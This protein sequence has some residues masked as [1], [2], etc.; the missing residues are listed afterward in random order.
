VNIFKKVWF[1]SLTLSAL[2]ASIVGCNSGGISMVDLT[3]M[4][5]D[6]G[7]IKLAKAVQKGDVKQI[8]SLIA[9]GVDPNAQTKDEGYNLLIVALLTQ[10]KKSIVALLEAGADP[11]VGDGEGYTVLHW[12]ASANDPSYLALL[13]EKGVDPNLRGKSGASALVDAIYGDR[14]ENFRALLAAGANPNARNNPVKEG[15]VGR[16]VLHIAASAA[17]SRE[18]LI[19][20][21]AGAEPTA[22]DARGNTFQRSFFRMSEDIMT[23]EGKAGREQVRAWL[24]ER[25]IPIKDGR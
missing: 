4:Y 3:K 14:E 22:L 7:V 20:L 25:N 1:K 13:L 9:V 10:N 23:D 17:T 6:E 12:A 16:T 15:S 21:V 18:I 24:K 8:K 5:S 19:L 2:L 11:A